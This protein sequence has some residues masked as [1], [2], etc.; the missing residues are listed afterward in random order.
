[1]L[2][3]GASRVLQQVLARVTLSVGRDSEG[4]FGTASR[5]LSSTTRASSAVVLGKATSSSSGPSAKV[6]DAQD[7]ERPAYGSLLP[8]AFYVQD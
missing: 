3:G 1:M 5:N 4:A 8:S 7:V 6:R 2:S